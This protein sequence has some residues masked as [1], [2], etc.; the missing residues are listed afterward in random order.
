MKKNLLLP[1]MALFF[2]F[3]LSQSFA[4]TKP[5][6]PVAPKPTVV[7]Q[8][9]NALL[10]KYSCLACHKA[11]TKLIGPAYAEV[12]KKKYTPERM[13]ALIYKPEPKNWPGYPPM[14]ALPNVPKEDGLKIAKWI[15][16][17]AK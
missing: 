1:V 2:L 11:D 10:T 16:T 5:K 6:A 12:A 4:Q 17:L 9:I 8:D 7:P 3:A 13:L 15:N 14:A